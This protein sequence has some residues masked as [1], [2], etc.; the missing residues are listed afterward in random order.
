MQP[1]ESCQLRQWGLVS[2][3]DQSIVGV[4]ECEGVFTVPH[5]A[6]GAVVDRV[7]IVAQT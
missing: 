1:L 5:I 2:S 4:V 3:G 6:F 7:L